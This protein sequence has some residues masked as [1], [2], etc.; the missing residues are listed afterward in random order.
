MD[1]IWVCQ[2]DPET[3]QQ[4]RVCGSSQ[5]R[6]HLW[7]SKQKCFQTNDSVVVFAVDDDDDDDDNDDAAAADDDDVLIIVVVSVIFLLYLLSLLYAHC[8]IKHCSVA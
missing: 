7:N 3:K 1:E 6:A 4:L 5:M 8:L 2:C